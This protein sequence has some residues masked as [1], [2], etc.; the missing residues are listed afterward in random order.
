[1]LEEANSAQGKGK[2]HAYLATEH[3]K[4]ALILL[5]KEDEEPQASGA[6]KAA[7]DPKQTVAGRVLMTWKDLG[8]TAASALLEEETEKQ[9][10][11]VPIIRA[12][13]RKEMGLRFRELYKEH[14]VAT[15]LQRH[16][17][18]APPSKVPLGKE[19]SA[20][21]L[22]AKSM[23]ETKIDEGARLSSP[24]LELCILRPRHSETCSPLRTFPSAL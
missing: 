6:D 12:G 7:A 11:P 9:T 13:P 4:A 14:F 21:T 19:P 23:T 17:S 2:R 16:E 8:E 3:W 10:V 22:N 5:A 18:P 20:D 24:Q 1:M 15:N